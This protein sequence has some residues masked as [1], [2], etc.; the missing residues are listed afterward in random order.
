MLQLVIAVLGAMIL[1]L[2]VIGVWYL[3]S[4]LVLL[5]ASRLFPLTG[6]KR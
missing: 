2:F 5:I 4:Y 6:R 1:L 3:G